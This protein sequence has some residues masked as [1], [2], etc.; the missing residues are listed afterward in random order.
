MALDERTRDK[1]R[2]HAQRIADEAPPLT[3]EQKDYLRA[4]LRP[5]PASVSRIEA[6]VDAA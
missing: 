5:A 1:I 2:A 4:L 6:D 3:A